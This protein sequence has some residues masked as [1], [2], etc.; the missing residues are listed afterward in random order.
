MQNVL[1]SIFPFTYGPRKVEST[2]SLLNSR[3]AFVMKFVIIPLILWF[4]P[5]TPVLLGDCD[6]EAAWPPII[7][8]G[9]TTVDFNDYNLV[10]IG[11]ATLVDFSLDPG[12]HNNGICT[13]VGCNPPDPLPPC[14]W[15]YQVDVLV[16]VA[17]KP[18]APEFKYWLKLLDEDNKTIIDWQGPYTMPVGGLSQNRTLTAPNESES[19]YCN[20][21]PVESYTIKIKAETLDD[22]DPPEWKFGKAKKIAERDVTFHCKNCPGPP[23]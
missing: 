23:D 3:S 21:H 2:I 1:D 5:S 8:T 13:K 4:F 11:T 9:P 14:V 6:C 19:S 15:R 10:A 18:N 12:T 22:S 17:R 7:S 20:N 16:N